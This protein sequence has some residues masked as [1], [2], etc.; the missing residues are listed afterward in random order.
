MPG[1]KSPQCGQE[2]SYLSEKDRHEFHSLAKILGSD[3]LWDIFHLL[4]QPF[5]TDM[6]PSH[7][8][9]CLFAFHP[10]IGSSSGE[11]NLFK[12]SLSRVTK[13]K[14]TVLFAR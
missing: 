3:L 5:L 9:H 11:K 12:T 14:I 2:G 1:K 8:T 7:P 10:L 6:P 4:E 13:K